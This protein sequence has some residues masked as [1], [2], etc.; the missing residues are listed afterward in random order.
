MAKQIDK[1]PRCPHCKGKMS[2]VR[3]E[4]Y[5]EK[6]N[7]W[8]CL[9]PKCEVDLEEYQSEDTVKGAFS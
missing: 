8:S 6:F 1:R 9:N 4:G 3:Y 2:L 5:Y 7:Y